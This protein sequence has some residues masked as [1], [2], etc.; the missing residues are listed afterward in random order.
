MIPLG[1]DRTLRV[2]EI[3]PGEIVRQYRD[4]TPCAFPSLTA[5]LSRS[6]MRFPCSGQ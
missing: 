2:V 6:T 5:H 3:R 1:R 4:R